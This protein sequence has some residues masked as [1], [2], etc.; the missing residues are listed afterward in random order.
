MAIFLGKGQGISLSKTNPSLSEIFLGLGWDVPSDSDV[1]FD[2][3]AFA[4]L[5]GANEKLISDSHLIFYNNLT[6]PDPHQSVQ[7]MGDNSTGVGEGD[8]EVIK[9]NLKR[10][11]AE[12]QKIVLAVTIF[13]AEE[14]NQNFGQ[15]KNAFVRLVNDQTQEEVL[16]YNLEE[17][18]SV[19]TALIMAELYRQDGGW[20][21]KAVG[22]GH[23]GG[24]Q[25][26]IDRYAAPPQ[27]AN[28]RQPAINW[29]Y[30]VAASNK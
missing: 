29:R 8:D 4:F 9:V 17:K 21:L 28:V 16:H 20:A 5:L 25:V 27:S 13:E 18:F 19:E 6:S 30:R 1:E 23:N 12:I 14:R 2:L 3:D 22:T 26:L 15:V 10:V 11:P 7:H 24:A